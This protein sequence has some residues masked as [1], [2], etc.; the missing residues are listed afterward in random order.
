MRYSKSHAFQREPIHCDVDHCFGSLNP[1]QMRSDFPQQQP[2]RLFGVV[3]DGLQKIAGLWHPLV[4]KFAKKRGLD[5]L[6]RACCCSWYVI[7]LILG[8]FEQN[9]SFDIK[10]SD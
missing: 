7:Y 9:Y 4:V 2:I 1:M 3:S 6:V 10:T 8:L 5:G